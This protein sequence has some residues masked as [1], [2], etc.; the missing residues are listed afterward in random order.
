MPLFSPLFYK[1]EDQYTT[2]TI[3]IVSVRMEILGGFWKCGNFQSL[4][5]GGCGASVARRGAVIGHPSFR[6]AH[7]SS[8]LLRPFFRNRNIKHKIGMDAMQC[9]LLSKAA[10]IVLIFLF[11]PI[12]SVA[13][14]FSL[15]VD[16]ATVLTQGNLVHP[17]MVSVPCQLNGQ[18]YK[19]IKPRNVDDL[20]DWYISVQ[21][22]P[23][24]DP[25]WA[26]LWPT[27]VSLSIYVLEHQDVIFGKR[28]VEL[29]SG[30]GLVG[31]VA[32]TAAKS[33][34]LTDREPMALHC[35]MSTA[36]C[37]KQFGNVQAA[38]LEWGNV[39]PTMQ[40]MADIVVASD[41]LYDKDT[42]R[43]LSE[44]CRSLLPPTGGL[45]MITDPQK[46]RT[47]GARQILQEALSR[48]FT[49]VA[50]ETIELDPIKCSSNPISPDAKDH[51]L[52]MKEST[53]LLKYSVC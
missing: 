9:P 21:N 11:C 33:V 20:Y 26:V 28:V 44:A 41:V 47:V 19:I 49:N 35:A 15:H 42:I 37:N 8:T 29:G 18:S 3:A 39:P 25:S 27:A 48:D 7:L 12:F 6:S 40:G 22:K 38:I 53:Y 50:I 16:D 10:L 5:T 17:P 30:L 4:L 43:A 45:V 36:A 51:T 24:A 13:F 32:S 52:R 34:L 1:L 14:S 23:D 2:T 46:E 31:L